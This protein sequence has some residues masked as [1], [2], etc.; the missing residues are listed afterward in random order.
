MKNLIK[1]SIV[2]FLIFSQLHSLSA[3]AFTD[4]NTISMNDRGASG[5]SGGQ[6]TTSSRPDR[7]KVKFRD[8]R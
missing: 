4:T 3:L 7:L 2:L 8:R 5:Q 6:T 1:T